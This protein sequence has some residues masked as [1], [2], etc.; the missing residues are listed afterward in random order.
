MIQDCDHFWKQLP[1]LPIVNQPPNG[2]NTPTGEETVARV[3]VH[4]GKK[5]L[6][7]APPLLCQTRTIG[8]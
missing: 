8:G 5:Q 6:S 7:D 2:S 3:P 1:P 4:P